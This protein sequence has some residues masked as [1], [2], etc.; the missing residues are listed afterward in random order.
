VPT[1]SL[2]ANWAG[3]QRKLGAHFS[4]GAKTSFRVRLLKQNSLLE[5]AK[6]D[7]SSFA[8]WCKNVSITERPSLGQAS[9]VL[10]VA[11]QLIFLDSKL[12]ISFHHVITVGFYF[13]IYTSMYI[14]TSHELNWTAGKL[15]KGWSISGTIVNLW[16]TYFPHFFKEPASGANMMLL[17][18]KLLH[19]AR[20]FQTNLIFA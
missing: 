16:R 13:S 4:V 5:L 9:L 11:P 10:R 6:S 18:T 1:S 20:K 15:L 14:L 12:F 7:T 3:R 19:E 8:P 2:G 17:V